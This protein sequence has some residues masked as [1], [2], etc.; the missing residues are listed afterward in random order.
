[1][2]EYDNMAHVYRVEYTHSGVT[3]GDPL[4]TV[5]VKSSDPLNVWREEDG[6]IIV[7][8]YSLVYSANEGGQC[9]T[10]CLGQT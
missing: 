7:D 8:E 9:L 3:L 6:Q 10:E 5:Q 1:M 2:S 4:K